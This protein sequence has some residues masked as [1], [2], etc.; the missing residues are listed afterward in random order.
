MNLHIKLYRKVLRP[1]VLKV[2]NLGSPLELW[3]DS[4]SLRPEILHIGAHLGQELKYYQ[5]SGFL[6][7]CWVEAQ[8]DIYSELELI[9]GQQNAMNCAVWSEEGTL[10][11][12]VSNNSVSSSLLKLG[13]NNPWDE[14][15]E[16]GRIKVKTK[17][18]DEVISGFLERGLLQ[19]KIF[20]VLDIQ[21]AELHAL[22]GLD[23]FK[24]KI[25]GISC[26]VSVNPTYESGAS[27]E[28]IYS[29]LKSNGFIPMAAFL[30]ERTRHGDQLFV[31][32]NLILQY[33]RLAIL[34]V[35]RGILLWVIKLK[36]KSK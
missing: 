27:R 8:P 6:K 5:E 26:E 9:V 11:F 16:V 10:E 20:L 18:L 12:N 13:K 17:T 31:R 19:D 32:R 3:A 28:A 14:I 25:I 24:N 23:R 15:K 34:T 1:H 36:N 33:P 21:G 2:L 4:C 35:T 29:K 22:A 30:D 7:C